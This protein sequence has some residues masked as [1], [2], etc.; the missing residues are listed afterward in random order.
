MPCHAT[1]ASEADARLVAD[2]FDIPTIRIDLAPAYDRLLADLRMAFMSLPPDQAPSRSEANDTQVKLP[3]VNVKPRLRMTT[4]YFV[5]NSLNKLVAG[6][7]NRSELTTGYFTKYGDGGVDLLPIGCSEERGKALGGS[8]VPAP[9]PRSRERR[10][11]SGQPRGRRGFVL[12][13]RELLT[14]AG[15]RARP[16]E[17]TSRAGACDR[18]NGRS[19]DADLETPASSRP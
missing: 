14:T 4:L 10:A 3:L 2:H 12:R 17:A 18:S 5:A 19:R 8:Q 7:G 9:I 11:V 13:S 6:T 1:R 15:S 16:G